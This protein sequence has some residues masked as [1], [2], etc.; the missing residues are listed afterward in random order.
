MPRRFSFLHTGDL[1]L[2]TPFAG[3]AGAAPDAIAARL[4]D[5]TLKAWDRIV[6]LALER[7]VDFVLVAGDVFEAETRTLRGQLAFADGLERLAVSG[8]P[9]AVVTGNH[10]PLSGWEASVAWPATAHRFGPEVEAFPIIRDGAEIARIYGISYA[11]KSETRD[12]VARFRR[13]GDTPF[14][15]G[16]LH[17]SVGISD[18]HERYAP[19]T[20]DELV[21]SGMD[22][23]ALGHVHARRIV[24]SAKPLIVYPGNPQGRDPGEAS[25]KGVAVVEV[26]ANGVPTPE[27]V[28][29]DVA[30]WVVVGV[31]CTK[32]ASITNL[33][34]EIR[35]AL[36]RAQHEAARS[37]VVRITLRGFTSLHD[38]LRRPGVAADLVMAIR[39]DYDTDAD[40]FVWLESIRDETRSDQET[41]YARGADFIAELNALV[42]ATRAS[43]AP[44]NQADV[45]GVPSASLGRE[46]NGDDSAPVDQHL[47][48]HQPLALAAIA[49][50]LYA[51]ARVRHVVDG[52]EPLELPA[53][54]EILEDARTL[55]LDSLRS[56]GN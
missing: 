46:G 2:D 24:R 7:G 45:H 10:D 9:T 14:A 54:D 22:Y 55:I 30:R 13:D 56:T 52:S 42:L 44:D 17:G 34:S 53:P 3:L 8:I 5:A 29:T 38:E 43:L 32:L 33:R 31:D 26:D 37:V 41:A 4:R 16:M 20:E 36:V 18:R 12:L 19:T 27:F 6:T 1:H 35:A 23:W 40:P 28:D 51:D 50:E 25:A 48:D 21:A 47:T 49:S 15:I 11:E 39:A